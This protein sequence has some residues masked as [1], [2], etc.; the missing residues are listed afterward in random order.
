MCSL[1]KPTATH[2]VTIPPFACRW[3]RAQGVPVPMTDPAGAVRQGPFL[4]AKRHLQP[5]TQP[6]AKLPAHAGCQQESGAGHSATLL[7]CDFDK[8][9]TDCD[10][11]EKACCDKEPDGNLVW[12][13]RV[14]VCS[15]GVSAAGPL[16]STAL[17]HAEDHCGTVTDCDCGGRVC[18]HKGPE[19]PSWVMGSAGVPC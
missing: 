17:W 14:A 10:A 1:T 8:T 18:W 3:F 4:Q 19:Q 6:A 15:A 16:C 9:L 11:G 7:L 2:F 12:G 13:F 5:A